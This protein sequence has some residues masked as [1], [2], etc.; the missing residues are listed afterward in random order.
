[1][2]ETQADCAGGTTCTEVNAG[3]DLACLPPAD[4]NVTPGGCTSDAECSGATPVCSATGVCVAQGDPCATVD[5][6]VGFTCVA[7]QCIEDSSNN[8]PGCT[9]DAQCG[10]DE[11]CEAGECVDDGGG[12]A[13]CN[14]NSDCRAGE[15]CQ[16]GDCIRDPN[17]EC[18]TDRDCTGNGEVCEDSE[19]VVPVDPVAQAC[20]AFCQNVYGSCPKNTCSGLTADTRTALD[21][22]FDRCLNGGTLDGMSVAPCVQDYNNSADFRD[23]VD[24]FGGET[25]G[26]QALRDVYCGNFGFGSQCNCPEPSVGDACNDDTDCDGGTL[27]AICIPEF[28][29]GESTGYVGGYCISGPCDAGSQE[30]GAGAL[31]AQTGCGEDGFCLNEQ[32][33]NGVASVCYQSCSFRS[34]C[35]SGYACEVVGFF[36]NGDPAGRCVPS[37]TTNDDCPVYTL[38]NGGGEL[39]SYCNP[40]GWCEVPCEPGGAGACGGNFTCTT[41][42]SFNTGTTYTGSCSF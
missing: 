19:C 6:Q 13:T 3:N 23:T 21:G 28:E 25:C 10:A 15:I 2:C 37:C 18:V 38:N 26:S 22:D 33:Q 30:V 1:V 29:N 14:F 17:V 12:G 41:R 11:V 9:S 8:P 36:T 20:L 39:N 24:Q 31:G 42:S 27:N 40:D 7:G 16:D 32:T 4:N 5:C 34:D 35:R